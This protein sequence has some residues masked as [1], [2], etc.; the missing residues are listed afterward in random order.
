[1]QNV[2]EV[3]MSAMS[4]LMWA[5]IAFWLG[6]GVYLAFL[7]RNQKLLRDRASQWEDNHG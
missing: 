2:C 4:W 7:A 1:M 5:N 3:N 6:L